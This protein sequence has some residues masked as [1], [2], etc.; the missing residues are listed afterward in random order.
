[1]PAGAVFLPEA[2]YEKKQPRAQLR[3]QGGLLDDMGSAP[4]SAF[5][6][7]D[8]HVVALGVA[9]GAARSQTA[10]QTLESGLLPFGKVSWLKYQPPKWPIIIGQTV[11]VLLVAWVYSSY[12]RHHAA[13]AGS[14]AVVASLPKEED[15]DNGFHFGLFDCENCCAR[16]QRICLCGWCCPGIRW[17][18]TISQDKN[19]LKISFWTLLLINLVCCVFNTATLGATGVIFLIPAIYYRQQLRKLFGLKFGTFDT[20][21]CD[22]LVWCF[23]SPCAAIQE[24]REVEYLPIKNP[25]D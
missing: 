23:C 19:H 12:Y 5:S 4:T 3:S 8:T 17:A 13:E 11:V 9:S 21:C 14:Q 24:A 18:D 2:A 15:L 6:L 22:L 20:C 1:V 10:S 16:D 7:I 25:T